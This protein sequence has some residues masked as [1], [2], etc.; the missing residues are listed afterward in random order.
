MVTFHA[1]TKGRVGEKVGEN[2]TKNQRKIL[3]HIKA[4]P[5]I[6]ARKLSVL[7]GISSRK[8]EQNIRK[9]WER[10]IL[11][12]IGPAKGGHWKVI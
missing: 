7:V 5:F 3:Q 11:Q 1:R 8:I 4:N 9:L 6:S 2:L 12:R 10:G